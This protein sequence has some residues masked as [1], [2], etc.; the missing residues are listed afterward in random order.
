MLKKLEKKRAIPLII[1]ILIATEI[2]FYST[3][4]GETSTGIFKLNLAIFYH[5]GIFFLFSFFLLITIK[6]E[7]KINLKYFLIVLF[8]SIAYGVSDEIHQYFVP[9]RSSALRDVV[10][11]SIGSLFGIGVYFFVDKKK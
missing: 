2:F 1:T 9:G 8:I 7:N 3:I 4:T 11:N 5:L 10:F 6:G